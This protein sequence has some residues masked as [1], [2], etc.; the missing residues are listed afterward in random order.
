M[1][2]GNSSIRKQFQEDKPNKVA[3][4][5]LEDVNLDCGQATQDQQLI[6]KATVPALEK[7]Q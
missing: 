4:S 6:P 1:D 5:T 2:H 3:E 7:R